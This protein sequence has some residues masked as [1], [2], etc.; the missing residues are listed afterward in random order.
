M[1][2]ES[3]SAH[4]KWRTDSCVGT[5]IS[6]DAA[7][8]GQGSY[9]GRFKAPPPILLSGLLWSHCLW[10]PLPI[11]LEATPRSRVAEN[12]PSAHDR[13][14]NRMAP[15]D[16]YGDAQGC[17]Y[18]GELRTLSVRAEISILPAAHKGLPN[19]PGYRVR[20]GGIEVGAGWHRTDLA[21]RKEYVSLSPSRG[22]GR[23]TPISPGREVKAR[24]DV[25]AL[26]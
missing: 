22:R 23:S 25:F 6:A 26:I 21:S 19:Q 11:P 13:T 5:D 10:R 3:Q 7:I 12:R 14:S 17:R 24:P 18:E 1:A 15:S 8:S 16:F 20:L 4:T 2:S 9:R